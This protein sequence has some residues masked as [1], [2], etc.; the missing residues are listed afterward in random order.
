M[1]CKVFGLTNFGVTFFSR[2]A[3]VGTVLLTY[4]LFR[5]WWSSPVAW[6][7]AFAM[8][9][10]STFVQFTATLRMDSLLLF[11]ILLS[12]TG[13][14]YHR[15]SWGAAAM[16]GGVTIAVLA[17][18]PLGFA[19]VPLILCHALLLGKRPVAGNGW[20][21]ALLLLPVVT[22]YAALVG[23]HG[24]RPFSELGADALRAT[25]SPQMGAWESIYR[26]YLVKPASRY[27]PWLP[28]TIV[29]GVMVVRGVVDDRVP[30]DTRMHYLWVLL[31]LTVVIATA[32]WK[33]DRDIRYLHPALPVLGL[34]S[35]LALATLT[36]HRL[37]TWIPVGAL[38]IVAIA[39][40]TRGLGF[41]GTLDTRDTLAK[42]R[43]EIVAPDQT[44]A[45]G[46]YPIRVDQPRRQ[47]THRDWIHFYMGFVPRVLSWDQTRT[48]S[49]DFS[50][51]VFMTRS[52][53]YKDRLAEFN[54]E[55]KYLTKEMIFAVPR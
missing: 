36:K 40:M 10:N 19:S 48:Q 38:I 32:V 27:W 47:N 8:L 17:K 28:F 18:G 54:L 52:R 29:G 5:R 49:P 13:W 41:W 12:L 16:F 31:W 15:A 6:L 14:A 2:L 7:S 11:G 53:G 44:I 33:P 25:A 24:I 43:T 21:W 4:A 34:F 9:T 20:W 23:L 46:G 45:I 42:I 37:P 3:G 26:E 39:M 55:A 1:S 50:S 51:G 35:G 30:R 22:W